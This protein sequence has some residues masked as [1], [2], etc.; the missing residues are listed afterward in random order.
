[1][2]IAKLLA[3]LIAVAPPCPVAAQ[4]AAG[5]TEEK[6]PATLT[7][8]DSNLDDVTAPALKRFGN[9]A[10]YMEYLEN[11]SSEIEFDPDGVYTSAAPIRPL[12]SLSYDRSAG[13]DETDLAKRVGFFLI[14]VFDG[15]IMSIDTR[16]SLRLADRV[17]IY[18]DEYNG[19][20]DHSLLVHRDH[21]IVTA[22]NSEEEGREIAIFRL[23]QV[24]GK[25]SH[26]GT[27]LVS[28]DESFTTDNI[29]YAPRIVDDTL[30]LYSQFSLDA[31]LSDEYPD[32]SAAAK[33]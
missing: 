10:S 16:D 26:E 20:D 12:P 24:T 9:E 11:F 21:I 13:I 30:V 32:T 18:E 7:F 31:P 19:A 5:S 4:P 3:L 25:L 14:T 27:F 2:D 17:N 23:D 8:E 15:R 28:A 33:Q 29:A 6:A 1:M 22:Y